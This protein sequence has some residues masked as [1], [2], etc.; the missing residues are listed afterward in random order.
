MICLS[1]FILR[2]VLFHMIITRDGK[3]KILLDGFEFPLELL[4]DIHLSF[5]HEVLQ[6][7]YY[8]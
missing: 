6:Y 2:E 8:S 4:Y 7:D 5:P 1:P 3:P